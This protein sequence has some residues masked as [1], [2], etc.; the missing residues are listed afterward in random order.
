MLTVPL[1]LRLAP[2]V[3]VI[4]PAAL[5]AVHAQDE[6]EVTVTLVDSPAAIEVLLAGLMVAVQA[7]APLWVT[8]KVRPAIV[9]VPVRC[10]VAEFAAMVMLT[11]PLPVPLAPAV[12]VIHPAL[13]TAVHAQ[14]AVTLT[15]VDSP[16]ARE[17][18]LAGLIV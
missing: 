17:V 3:T 11:V 1:P 10:A 18:L 7:C 8:V 14:V 16:A 13:L 5:T 12:T 15:L 6:V 4:H 9:T 2:A